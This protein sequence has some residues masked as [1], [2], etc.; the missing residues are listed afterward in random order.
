MLMKIGD[1][2][3]EQLELGIPFK[4]MPDRPPL[5]VKNQNWATEHM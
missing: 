3:V 2:E 5:N 4:A 1:K